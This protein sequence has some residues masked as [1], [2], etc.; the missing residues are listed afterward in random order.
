VDE[1]DPILTIGAFAKGSPL[2]MKVPR[3]AQADV[4]ADITN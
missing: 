3:D 4:P 1:T 2:S